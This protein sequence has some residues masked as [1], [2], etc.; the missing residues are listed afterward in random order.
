[1][2]INVKQTGLI[3]VFSLI[4]CACASLKIKVQTN[5]EENARCFRKIEVVGSDTSLF[6]CFY[7][8]PIHSKWEIKRIVNAKDSSKT[9]VFSQTFDNPNQISQSQVTLPNKIGIKTNFQKKSNWFST[10][11]IYE[12]VFPC[13]M[14]YRKVPINKYLTDKE[15]AVLYAKQEM[16]TWDT[17]AQVAILRT[18]EEDKKPISLEDSTKIEHYNKSLSDKFSLWL[19]SNVVYEMIQ[20]LKKDKA[21]GNQTITDEDFQIINLF[22]DSLAFQFIENMK[23]NATLNFLVDY[24]KLKTGKEIK[25]SEQARASLDAICDEIFSTISLLFDLN[26]KYTVQMP[27]TLV[28]SNATITSENIGTWEIPNYALLHGDYKIQI[29][30]RVKNPIFTFL[31][32]V[33]VF[34]LFSGLCWW[35]IMKNRSK[36]A[37]LS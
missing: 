29:T 6:K 20:I 26:M 8:L 11:Y 36:N 1:M 9:T 13:V 28:R 37:E 32:W 7:P 25:I 30:S 22:K 21:S 19:G 15:L 12:E 18:N 17:K 27:G 35:I 14:K 2:K 33:L 34:L 23:P 3:I 24:L 16:L 31:G 10:D 5:I 4:L